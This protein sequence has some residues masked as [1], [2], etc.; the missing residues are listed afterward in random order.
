MDVAAASWIFT[1]WAIFIP[2]YF[3]ANELE[4]FY[5]RFQTVTRFSTYPQ[6]SKG[7]G[8]GVHRSVYNDGLHQCGWC[9]LQLE[10]HC[11]DLVKLL[12]I[13]KKIS[14]PPLNYLPHPFHMYPSSQLTPSPI[15]LFSSLPFNTLLPPY[16]TAYPF[17]YSFP[18]FPIKFPNL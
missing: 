18:S 7:E 15:T 6:Q 4:S 12:K 1:V 10:R 16:H 9:P 13:K 8:M 2:N 11:G 17:L 3:G 14:N 5:D